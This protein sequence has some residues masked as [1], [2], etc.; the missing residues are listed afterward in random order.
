MNHPVRPTIDYSAAS[1]YFWP[2]RPTWTDTKYDPDHKKYI[3]GYCVI[4]ED[5]LLFDVN[6]NGDY[7]N[8]ISNIGLQ[9]I[10]ENVRIIV[11]MRWLQMLGR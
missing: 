1:K 11:C 9:F 5:L 10:K 3:R 4:D 8:P 6:N 2:D 7:G